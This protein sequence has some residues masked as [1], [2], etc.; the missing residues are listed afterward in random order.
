MEIVNINTFIQDIEENI[1]AIEAGTLAPDTCLRELPARDSLAVLSMLA[2]W[3]MQSLVSRLQAP[4]LMIVALTI[5]VTGASSGIGKEAAVACVQQGATI[6]GTGR[7]KERLAALLSE[8]GGRG[9]C[10]CCFRF[11]NTRGPRAFT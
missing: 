4:R 5:L 6:I 10:C 1:D 9:A 2:P 8:L 7:D 11:N 3:W